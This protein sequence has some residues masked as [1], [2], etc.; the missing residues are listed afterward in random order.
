MDASARL[1]QA[2]AALQDGDAEGAL[3]HSAAVLEAQPRLAV[4]YLVRGRA[5]LERGEATGAV[6][7]L[8]EAVRLDP[9][10][11]EAHVTLG[12]AQ[13][14]R[15]ELGDA[16]RHHRRALELAPRAAS[17]VTR[18]AGFLVDQGELDSALELYRAAAAL[19]SREAAGGWV[20]VLERRGALE[21]ATEVF[22]RE[23]LDPRASPRLALSVARL[24]RRQG[25]S[26]EALALLESLELARATPQLRATVHYALGECQDQRGD[27][28]QA[29][30]HWRAANRLRGVRF[31][32]QALEERL[33]RILAEDT[34]ARLA[35]RP[36]ASHGDARPT[37][38]VGAPRSGT[39]LVE[40]L[41]ATSP[42]VHARGELD[43]IPCLA[44]T[45]ARDDA[46]AVEQSARS[47]LARL[48]GLAPAVRRV[49]DKLPH[50]ALHLG[51][52]AQLCP[53][54]RVVYVTRD[55]LDTGLSIYA[56]DFQA[57]HDYATDLGAIGTFLRAHRRL[58]AHWREHLPL[59]LFELSYEH[60]VAAPEES[61]R[62]LFA[63]LDLP[64]EP[65]VLRF[66]E[67]RRAVRT[68]SFAAVR[69]PLH[70]GSVGRARAYRAW[71]GPLE[72]ALARP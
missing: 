36:R 33:A 65:T 40:E 8:A 27:H 37:F 57:T 22:A 26:D 41:L 52:I 67:S 32:A 9:G 61:T 42:A 58:L 28:A 19:G 55:P 17:I 71:L 11:A 47:Y 2:V 62:A 48:A 64:W 3:A 39:T 59:A 49:T 56:R 25:R 14:A 66:H 35:V 54:A 38:V 60:L 5:L 6:M 7:A 34:R 1:K 72:E 15:G 70:A 18:V 24:W 51:V 50:N 21:E 12:A 53:E 16:W 68:A 29:F 10:S 69:R 13:A 20:E 23:R 63:F 44:A 30:A 46:S 4:A 43:E 31:D 45:L